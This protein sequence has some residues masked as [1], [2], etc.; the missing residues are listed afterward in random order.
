MTGA[1]L[2]G[3]K[4]RRMGKDKAF[5]PVDGAAIIERALAVFRE[6]FDDVI[7]IANDIPSYERLSTPVFADI[8]QGGGSLGGI[9][10]AL[11]HSKTANVF[12]AA[13]DMPFLDASAIKKITGTG[14]TYDA[15][16]PFIDGRFHPM[17]AMYSK[18]CLPVMEDMIKSGDLKIHDLLEKVRVKKLTLDDFGAIPIERSVANI[19]TPD[20][21]GKITGEK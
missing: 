17:H 13:C 1:I 8:I 9:Y 7:I 20:E 14:G 6:V 19:N 12:V 2:S 16:V 18:R 3:G 5:I 4:S 15:V 21:L 10:T 11:I